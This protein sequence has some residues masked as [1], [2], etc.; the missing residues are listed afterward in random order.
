MDSANFVQ[1]LEKQLKEGHNCYYNHGEFDYREYRRGKNRCSC[2]GCKLD[3]IKP[4]NFKFGR[5]FLNK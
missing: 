5:I 2:C 1:L 3:N 4:L